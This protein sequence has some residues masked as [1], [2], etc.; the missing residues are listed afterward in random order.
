MGVQTLRRAPA[1]CELEHTG[2]KD[3]R[4][5]NGNDVLSTPAR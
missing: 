1:L 3:R 2:G 4:R 5:Y